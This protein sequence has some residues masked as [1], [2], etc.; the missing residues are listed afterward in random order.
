MATFIFIDIETTGIDPNID[1]IIEIACAKW[2]NGKIT[3]KFESLVKP[4][5][6]V[7]QE[8]TFITGITTEMVDSAP[9]FSE[10]K[11]KVFD[12]IGD[13][14]V[15]GH[16]IKFDTSFLKSHHMD[17]KNSEIDTLE[18]A[19]ILLLKEP[20]YALEVLM[21]KYGLPLRDSHRAMADVETT[22]AFFEFLMARIK[23]IPQKLW[24]QLN[25]ILEKTSWPGKILFT[26][27][28]A[29]QEKTL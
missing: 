7:P 19:R 18:L 21:K 15:I 23:E 8:V 29:R 14:I 9:R 22:I 5:V 28:L 6:P 13:L 10:I 12:F 3:E 27:L 2:E 17:L 26:C 25:K 20:S 16:N 1:H 24:P 4:A 11:Q